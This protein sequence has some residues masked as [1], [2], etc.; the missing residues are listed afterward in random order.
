MKSCKKEEPF[1]WFHGFGFSEKE[2]VVFCLLSFFKCVYVLAIY[3][4]KNQ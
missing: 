3:Y 2:L 1:S 4:Q